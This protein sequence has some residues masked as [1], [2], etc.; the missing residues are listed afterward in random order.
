M[1]GGVTNT[2]SQPADLTST[3]NHPQDTIYVSRHYVPKAGFID[4]IGLPLETAPTTGAGS[5][6]RTLLIGLYDIN[7]DGDGYPTALIAPAFEWQLTNSAGFRTQTK[8]LS[9]RIRIDRP[10]RIAI[11]C[12]IPNTAFGAGKVQG[13]I[14]SKDA[15]SGWTRSGDFSAQVGG[16]TYANGLPSLWSSL[17]SPT[18]AD[19]ESTSGGNLRIANA[20]WILYFSEQ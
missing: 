6:A 1:I 5:P 15:K 20:D 7:D 12:R 2:G 13:F 4:A 11:A 16:S 9:S 18:Y 3:T 17:S 8:V 19:L 14:C 10:K